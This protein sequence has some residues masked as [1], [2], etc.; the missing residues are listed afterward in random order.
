MHKV[1]PGFWGLHRFSF[2]TRGNEWVRDQMATKR[3]I[4]IEIEKEK[5]GA[6]VQNTKKMENEGGRLSTD[7]KS[8]KIWGGGPGGHRDENAKTGFMKSFT[9]WFQSTKPGVD[10][11]EASAGIIEGKAK[12]K[13]DASAKK[14]PSR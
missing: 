13:N 12:D 1:P 14:K 7:L 8:V 9:S 3:R 2:Q 11:R 4:A 5:K 6:Q 10:N